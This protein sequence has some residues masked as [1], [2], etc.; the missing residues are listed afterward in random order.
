MNT[1]VSPLNSNAANTKPLWVAV[2]LL[3]AAVLAMGGGLI[4]LQTHPSEPK[5]A[6]LTVPV[7]SPAPQPIGMQDEVKKPAEVP[8]VKEKIAT[9]PV[10]IKSDKAKSQTPAVV[11]AGPVVAQSAKPLC[12]ACATVESSA[13]IQ[14]EAAGSGVGA[15][16]GG[17]LGAVLGNQVGG[18]DGKTAAT[19]LGA[20]GGGWAGNQ[21]EKKMKKE[22]FYE[23]RVRMDDG[24]TRLM[25]LAA[26]V[27]AGARVTV[28]GN[29]LRLPDGSLV[30]PLPVKAVAPTPAEPAPRQG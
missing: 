7:V 13:P 15:V 1:S 12:V 29:S 27:S 23:V 8:V 28:E 16:A 17:V 14:R 22:T 2:G 6:A 18:G 24:S 20:L 30:N 25:E 26:P 4:Y 10:A 9:K 19:I 21:V 11:A 5:V 3:G